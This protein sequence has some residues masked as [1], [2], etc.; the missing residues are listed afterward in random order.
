[1]TAYTS[2]AAAGSYGAHPVAYMNETH[3]AP[4]FFNGRIVYWHHARIE[5]R[6]ALAVAAAMAAGVNEG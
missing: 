6:E 1:M 5:L 3:F 2:S 4:W